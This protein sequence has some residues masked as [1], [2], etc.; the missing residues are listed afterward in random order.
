MIVQWENDYISLTVLCPLHGAGSI[1]GYG[2]ESQKIFL[3]DQTLPT[4]PEPTDR[5]WLNNPSM[6]PHNLRILKREA[7]MLETLTKRNG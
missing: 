2:V 4:R 5:K 7:Y 6:A 3:T 1:P